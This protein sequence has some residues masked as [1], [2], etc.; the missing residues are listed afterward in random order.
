[1]RRIVNTLALIFELIADQLVSWWVLY[2]PCICLR[3]KTDDALCR[4]PLYFEA[5]IVFILWLTLPRFKG[6]TYLYEQV[7]APYLSEYEGHIDHHLDNIGRAASAGLEHARAAG[8]QHVREHSVKMLTTIAGLVS[9]NASEP[10]PTVAEA[11]E[12]AGDSPPAPAE[13]GGRSRSRSASKRR[14][15]AAEYDV[16]DDAEPAESAQE[17]RQRRK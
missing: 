7:V 17:I 11:A 5:K 13:G 8:A 12:Q 1:M 14:G 15:G 10:L 3:V 6:A 9:P 2:C 16:D 4:L